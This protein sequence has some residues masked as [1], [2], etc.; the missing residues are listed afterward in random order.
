MRRLQFICTISLFRLMPQTVKA[1]ISFKKVGGM[2][3]H[4]FFSSFYTGK[5]REIQSTLQPILHHP[6]AGH[7]KQ[8][9]DAPYEESSKRE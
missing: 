4:D 5:K 1:S 9:E 8:V 7:C 6:Q 3:E 2:D